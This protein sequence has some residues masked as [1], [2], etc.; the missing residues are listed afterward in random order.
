M[1]PVARNTVF[2]LYLAP[3]GRTIEMAVSV[4]LVKKGKEV[5]GVEG[6]PYRAVADAMEVIPRTPIQNSGRNVIQVL[7]ELRVRDSF[8]L[9]GFFSWFRQLRVAVGIFCPV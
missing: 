7:T 4:G 8:L 5:E 6:G 9:F 1:L 3:D 2:F